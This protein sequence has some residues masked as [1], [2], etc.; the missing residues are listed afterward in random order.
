MS[1]I[2]NPQIY[3]CPI[4]ND[5]GYRQAKTPSGNEAVA[6]CICLLRRIKRTFFGDLFEEKTLDN[7]E[8]RNASMRE[9]LRLIKRNP[10]GSFYIY[11]EVGLGKTHLL[12]AI[13]EKYYSSGLWLE[14]AILTETQ[15]IE[16]IKDGSI[17]EKLKSKRAFIIDD[18]GKIRVADWQIEMLFN[19]YNDVYRYENIIVIS[20]N[21]TLQELSG[22]A[23]EKGIYSPAIARRIAERCT[24]LQIQRGT[25]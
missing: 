10:E 4:C 7:Y 25:N 14:T 22:T 11:G 12:A 3:K 15:L 8:G 9:A 23:E 18:I 20:S 1:S 5:I 13:Y 6:P 24:I 19:F 2:K 17:R 21:Y 16:C